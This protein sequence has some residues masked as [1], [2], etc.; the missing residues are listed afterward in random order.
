MC[1]LGR[2][3]HVPRATKTN[4]HA[5]TKKIHKEEKEEVE[6]EVV[7]VPEDDGEEVAE[8]NQD[9]DNYK[10]QKDKDTVNDQDIKKKKQKKMG[11]KWKGENEDCQ[12]IFPRH[13]ELWQSS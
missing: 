3:P 4:P 13:R 6:N 2:C 1:C 7:A 8:E 10:D 5:R 12:Q 9:K 11:K